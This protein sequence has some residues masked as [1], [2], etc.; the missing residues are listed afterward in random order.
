MPAAVPTAV[1]ARRPAR[2]LCRVCGPNRRG[3]APR[4]SARS[5]VI[6]TPAARTTVCCERVIWQKSVTRGLN[7]GRKRV[8]EP[9]RGQR[10]SER[11]CSPQRV[12]VS[13]RTCVREGAGGRS[14]PP[15]VTRSAR[16][17][18]A[19][20]HAPSPCCTRATAVS[21][22][23]VTPSSLACAVVGGTRPRGTGPRA[24]SGSELGPGRAR[25]AAQGMGR[26]P[27]PRHTGEAPGSCSAP[28]G[29]A[30]TPSSFFLK[31]RNTNF[32]M[33]NE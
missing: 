23:G 12:C 6:T 1:P 32:S 33:I 15:L 10:A 22:P 21:V 28:G 30:C 24:I 9:G 16:W 25:S 7:H 8:S 17:P 29:Q 31:R 14:R 11:S 26:V 2:R 5:L 4:V 18:P 13:L 20:V 3:L 19:A 27:H